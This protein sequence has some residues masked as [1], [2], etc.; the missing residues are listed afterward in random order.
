MDR[1]AARGIGMSGAALLALVLTAMLALPVAASAAPLKKCKKRSAIECGGVSV[2]L[3]RTGAVPGRVKLAVV[4]LPARKGPAKGTVV[5][6]AG[7]P[8]ESAIGALALTGLP[9]ARAL[10]RFDVVAFDQRGTGESSRLRC[11]AL[12]KSGKGRSIT[13]AFARCA[14]QIGPKRAFSRTTDSVDDL[15]AVR[16][17][18]KSPTLSL[19][20][21]SYGARV[22]GE[23]ARRYPASTAR[24]VLDSP[25]PLTGSDPFDRQALSALPRV[26]SSLCAGKACPFTKSP[27]GDLTR[28]ARRLARQPLRGRLVDARGRHRRA[29]L[30]NRLLHALVSASDVDPLLR[31]QL[32]AGIA[33]ALKG[34]PAP[35]LRI[36]AGASSDSDSQF[37]IPVTAATLCS[38]SPLPWDPAGAPGPG[39]S[40]ALSAALAGLGSAPFAPFSPKVATG[41]GILS[42]CRRWPAVPNKP[43]PLGGASAVPS[44][45][46]SGTEDL[47]TPYEQARLVAGDYSGARLL[48]VPHTGHSV[49]GSA[50]GRCATRAVVDFLRGGSPA[51]ACPSKSRPSLTA[52]AK[53]PPAR[54]AAVPGR[55]RAQRVR[56]AARLT[57]RDAIAQVLTKGRRFGGLRGGTGRLERKRLVLNDYEY[58]S[59]V[60]LDGHLRPSKGDKPAGSVFVSV[61][62]AAPIFVEL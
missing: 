53:L 41:D 10:P 57:A 19:L 18:L 22:A 13:A 2:P 59:G 47:R 3:D 8:G 30:S 28:L 6:I 15:E 51:G 39:R 27:Y 17:Y 55:T 11:R 50:V 29:A 38:E 37:S 5:L 60:R 35:L 31:G 12:S 58:V 36:A 32:P 26:L 45:I 16:R 46:L 48:A 1:R 7:G 33:S 14:E 25:V 62:A 56:I 20:A 23:Y 44:L 4:R 61:G 24:L 54:L 42:I 43:A 34:D 21:I 49:L 52:I 9:L 40:A